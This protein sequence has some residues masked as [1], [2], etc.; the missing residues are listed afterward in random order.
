MQYIQESRSGDARG[1]DPNSGDCPFILPNPSIVTVAIHP[2]PIAAALGRVADARRAV[3]AV[4][5]G[6]FQ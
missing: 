6:S 2:Y 5:R 3:P 4:S 1:G